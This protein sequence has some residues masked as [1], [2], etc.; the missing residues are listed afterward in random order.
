M[1]DTSK[2]FGH[3]L[4]RPFRIAHTVWAG[5][6]LLGC[7]ALA[8]GGGHPPPIVF[9]P[10]LILAG[11]VGHLLLLLVAWLMHL[12][13]SRSAAPQSTAPRWPA[14]LVLVAIVLGPLALATTALALSQVAQHGSQPRQWLVYVVAATVHA[15]AF[16]VLLLRWQLARYMVA[17]ICLGWGLALALQFREPRHTADLLVAIV[18]IAALLAIAAY[19]MLGSR[20]RSALR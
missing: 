1:P 7:G 15:M 10:L 14:E 13:K 8:M 11:L 20:I 5:L 3:L 16:V 17:A 4:P 2:R 19:V 6:V 18:V 12:G 9:A